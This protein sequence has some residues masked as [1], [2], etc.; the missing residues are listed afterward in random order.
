MCHYRLF[1]YYIQSGLRLFTRSDDGTPRVCIHRIYWF[2]QSVFLGP[3]IKKNTDLRAAAMTKSEKDFFKLMNNS[4][5]GKT[6]ENVRK[7]S[8]IRLCISEAQA[9]FQTNKP[10]CKSVKIFT[11]NVV[12]VTMNK[13]AVTLN[14]PI[15]IGAAILELSKLHMFRFYYDYLK[16]KYPK[17]RILY[18]DI[19]SFV[20]EIPTDDFYADL[21]E[22][23]IA[24]EKAGTLDQWWY[25]TSDFPKDSPLHT[26]INKKVIGKIKDE[27]NRV[28]LL[29]YVA[30]RSKAYCL[31]TANKK[32]DIKKLKGMASYVV[33]KEIRFDSYIRCLY[34]GDV[35]YS[36]NPPLRSYSHKIYS[37]IHKKSLEFKNTKRAICSRSGKP[38]WCTSISI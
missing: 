9:A 1:Q 10:N 7:R 26:N 31:K 18:S 24:H 5:F 2:D 17:C 15:Q 35:T 27:L 23:K 19:D 33:K 22:E 21:L 32:T 8:D 38:V 34:D 11:E 20:L 36:H 25:D 14:K 3:Y 30:L 29:E 37:T 4:C 6:M 12:A 28:L 13:T 16:P